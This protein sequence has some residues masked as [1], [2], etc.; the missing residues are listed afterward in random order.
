VRALNNVCVYGLRVCLC[1]LDY[2]RV[3]VYIYTYKLCVR[4]REY[5]CTRETG[6]EKKERDNDIAKKKKRER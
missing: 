3:F 2:A 1:V 4:V 5:I 6:R